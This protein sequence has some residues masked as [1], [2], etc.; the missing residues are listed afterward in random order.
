MS[1]DSPGS[2]AVAALEIADIFLIEASSRVI[3]D[4]NNQAQLLDVD[5]KHSFQVE[6][7]GL[8]QTRTAQETGEEIHIIRYF[9]TGGLR[10][11]KPDVP[12]EKGEF[13]A[14]DFLAEVHAKFAVDYSSP[15]GF[16][17]DIDAVAAFSTNAQFHA[18]AYWREVVHSQL[19]QMRLPRVTIPMFK[20]GVPLGHPVGT[21]R[22][23]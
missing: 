17:K 2:R 13:I 14:D 23:K 1:K 3:H 18:W 15:K 7:S 16:E 19:A 8:H 10:M 6:S 11:L 5:S 4:F 12:R 21:A 22:K 20:P 9:V